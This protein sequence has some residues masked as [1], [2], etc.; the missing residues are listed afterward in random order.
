MKRLHLK[1]Y[2]MDFNNEAAQ[3]DEF[4]VRSNFYDI[5]IDL[6]YEIELFLEETSWLEPMSALLNEY[7]VQ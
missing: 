2:E 4:Q 7:F 3:T 1:N 6:S 5:C